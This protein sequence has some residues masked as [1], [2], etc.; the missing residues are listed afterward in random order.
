[1]IYLAT[2][3]VSGLTA[4]AIALSKGRNPRAWFVTGA[5]AGPLGLSIV[6]LADKHASS[7]T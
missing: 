6:L 3:L 2:A 7:R 1:M 4:A 5:V